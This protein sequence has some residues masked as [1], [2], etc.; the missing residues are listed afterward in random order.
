MKKLLMSLVAGIALG[1]A[2]EVPFKI[3]IA[4][5][6]F[7]RKSLDESLAI[8]KTIDCHYLCHKAFFV[9]Y[10]ASDADI[11]AYKAKL[12]AANVKTVATG[13]L[14][15]RYDDTCEATVR[16]QFEFAKKLG[17]RVLVGVPYEVLPGKKDSWGPN[18]V[19][20]D[21]MLDVI[22]KL[23]KE[24]D[25][26]YAIHNHG[27]DTPTLFPTAEAAMKRIATRDKRIGVCLDIGH[28][29]R[30]GCDPVAFIRK[31]ADR[32][33][34]VHLKNLKFDAGKAITMQG[35]RGDLDIQGVFQA[36][37]DVGYTGVCHIEYER[38]FN[39]NA[40]GLAE[41]F[42]YYR[43]IADCIRPNPSK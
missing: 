11:A 13:P 33:Y 41:S 34:D 17:I 22:E 28:E 20:S 36:L 25:M 29:K 6:T 43:G 27:P 23:V 9:K 10:D 1:A 31:H 12:D 15:V 5:Y 14:Y 4:G 39:D 18:R 7:H 21:K 19:E 16:K 8:M 42:G 3:G 37:T 26:Y 32:I 24:Y 35:P 2:A 40:M 30:S 38:D